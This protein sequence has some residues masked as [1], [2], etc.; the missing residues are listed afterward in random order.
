MNVRTTFNKPDSILY[1]LRALVREGTMPMDTINS[2]V[3]DVLRVKFLV[4][5]FDHPYVEDLDAAKKLVGSP[6]HLNVAL[7]ASREGIVLLKNKDHILPL[8][9]SLHSLAVIGPNADDDDYAHNQ[10]GPTGSESISV[11]KGIRQWASGRVSVQYAKGCDLV[12]SH[13][14]ESEILPEPLT[15]E[16]QSRIDSAVALVWASDAAV[17]VLG[18]NSPT[19]GE[20]KSRT[21]LDLPGHQLDLIRAIAA[22]GKPVVVVLIGSQPMTI[23]WID[24]NISGIIYAGYPGMQGGTAVAEVLFG[25]YN[26]GGKLTL[27]WPKSVGQLPFNFPTKPGSESDQGEHAKIKG[28]LYPFGYGLSYTTFTYSHLTV[29]PAVQHIDGNLSISADITNSGDKEGDEV[30]QL[31]T[32]DEVSSVTTYEKNLRGFQRIHLKPGETQTVH[33]TLVPEDLKLWNRAMQHVVEPGDFTV[34]LGS[35]SDDIRL[36]GSFTITN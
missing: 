18:G 29:A 33:F 36:R 31:Y 10:Y 32:R 20:S 26:P 19:A 4:G 9:A 25:E 34:M 28:L 7:Q 15:A 30:V 21:D 13:W 14:P 8:S 17:V 24:R 22:V 35:S 3:R 27:T 11:L 5:I 2:R 16:E 12:D 6:A 23:N 1:Y